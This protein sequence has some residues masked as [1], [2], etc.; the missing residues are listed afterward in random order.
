LP[1]HVHEHG[2]FCLVLRGA[3]TETCHS[4]TLHCKPMTVLY[5]A[6]GEPH[7]DRFHDTGGQCCVVEVPT[8]WV[9]RLCQGPMRAETSEYQGGALSCLALRLCEELRNWDDA[10]GF[11]IQGLILEMLA[12]VCRSRA[13]AAERPTAPWLQRCREILHARFRERIC[14]HEIA[15]AVNVHSSHLARSFRRQHRCTMGEYVRRLRI[16]FAC[17]Q[18]ASSGTSLLDVALDAGFCD[19]S[20]F[21][22]TFKRHT[23]LTPSEFRRLTHAR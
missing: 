22:K 11:A 21:C 12:V 20:Q 23:G 7:A 18:L 16:D 17:R 9:D 8:A 13:S 5:R 1:Q 3:Y 2:Y 10:S 19:Q 15:F 6:P 14:L 4:S